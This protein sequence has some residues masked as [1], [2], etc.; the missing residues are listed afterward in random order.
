MDSNFRKG[1]MGSAVASR[2]QSC[3]AYA[4][5]GRAFGELD[6]FGVLRVLNRVLRGEGEARKVR[7]R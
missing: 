6:D 3:R 1:A 7:V 5:R 4:P 2:K